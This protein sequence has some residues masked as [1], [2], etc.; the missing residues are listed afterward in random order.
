MNKMIKYVMSLLMVMTLCLPTMQAQV[1]NDEE[2]VEDNED[3]AA[4]DS[5][6]VETIAADTLR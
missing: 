6:M 1:V 5:A 2:V 3:S 4:A